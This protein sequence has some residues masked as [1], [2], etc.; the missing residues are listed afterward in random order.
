MGEY[1]D[2]HSSLPFYILYAMLCSCYAL[3]ISLGNKTVHTFILKKDDR[4][5]NN[6]VDKSALASSGYLRSFKD[7][8]FDCKPS[9]I[10]ANLFKD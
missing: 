5:N 2:G 3:C 4:T 8:S 6:Q 10:T 9:S 7:I 1:F